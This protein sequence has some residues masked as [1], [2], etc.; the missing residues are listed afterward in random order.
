MAQSIGLCVCPISYFLVGGHDLRKFRCLYLK[1]F[2]EVPPATPGEW[3]STISISRLCVRFASGIGS[4]GYLLLKAHKSI[5]LRGIHF[6]I[7]DDFTHI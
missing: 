3:E 2:G 6:R 1:A 5:Y 4:G 7:N